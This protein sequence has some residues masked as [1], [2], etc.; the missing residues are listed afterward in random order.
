[1]SIFKRLSVSLGL[2]GAMIMSANLPSVSQAAE[3]VIYMQAM[4]PK[5]TTSAKKEPFPGKNLPGGG[6][7][8]IKPPNKKGRWQVSIYIWNPSQIIVQKGDRVTLKI[9]GLNG[10]KHTG[11]IEHYHPKHFIVKRGR[12]TTVQFTA[13]K[14]GRFRIGCEDHKPTMTGDLIVL[15]N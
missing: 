7:Y 8:V 15:A 9:L 14:A 5:G 1:M 12:I 10:A 13:S 2:V 6:G 3:R 11:S 4:E